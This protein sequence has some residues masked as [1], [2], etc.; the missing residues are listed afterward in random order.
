MSHFSIVLSSFS[1]F[2]TLRSYSY[3]ILLVYFIPNLSR[4]SQFSFATFPNKF[5][6]HQ[7]QVVFLIT[8]HACF[9]LFL[10]SFPPV[11]SKCHLLFFATV[12]FPY[13][14]HVFVHFSV[15]LPSFSL[16]FLATRY[17]FSCLPDHS[18]FSLLLLSFLRHVRFFFS[19]VLL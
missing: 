4:V 7:L 13:F 2:M 17:Y 14:C 11:L 3:S 5:E 15:V 1:V 18:S 8:S 19:L 9:A 16:P 12:L 10:Y 6:F